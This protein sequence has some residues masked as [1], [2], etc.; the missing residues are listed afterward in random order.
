MKPIG[1]QGAQHVETIED[2][3]RYIQ[4]YEVREVDVRTVKCFFA[5]L[6]KRHGHAVTFEGLPHQS[7]LVPVIFGDQNSGLGQVASPFTGTDAA[8]F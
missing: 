6:G 7:R 2:R 5:V 3:H 1:L 8:P 4:D